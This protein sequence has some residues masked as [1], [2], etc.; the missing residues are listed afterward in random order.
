ML[1]VDLLVVAGS[2]PVGVAA[3]VDLVEA[4]ACCRVAPGAPPARVRVVGGD[5]GQVAL[6]GGLSIAAI[7]PD[8][9]TGAAPWVV[10]PGIGGATPADLVRRLDEPDTRAATV[11]L[12]DAFAG[13]ARVAASCTGTLLAAEAGVLTGRAATTTWWLAGWFARR[14][15]SVRL[16][17]DRMLVRD[18]P[19]LTAGAVLGHVDLLLA[20]V[21]EELGPDATREVAG[22][23]AATPR[24]SQAPFRRAA[25]YGEANPDLAAVERFV[26]EHLDSPISLGQLAA[27]TRLSTRTLARRVH[28]ATGL[29]P[30][31]FVQRIR[32]EIAVDLL[33][34][35]RRGLDEVARAV[36]VADAASLHRLMRR[37]TGRSPGSFRPPAWP[38]RPH[39]DVRDEPLAR[40]GTAPTGR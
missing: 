29:P 31:R 8:R 10:V 39:A 5:S 34:D 26:L 33:R 13:G 9:T 2:G 30:I 36:G 12:A 35:R 40:T 20:V 28:A 16:D 37:V 3:T 32:V 23:I 18:G 19:V 15:P 17:A 27:A 24:G 4:L 6:R 1:D 22:R 14:H 21:A 38:G 25:L 11:W 7:P